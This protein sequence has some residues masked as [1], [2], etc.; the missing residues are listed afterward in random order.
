MQ[1]LE[2]WLRSLN[3]GEVIAALQRGEQLPETRVAVRGWAIVFVALPKGQPGLE[4]N[5]RLVGIGPV[6][7]G[8]TNDVSAA[9]QTIAGKASRYGE[10]NAPFVVA[11]LQSWPF[12]DRDAVEVLYG[13]EAVRVDPIDANSGQLVRLR[14]GTWAT[15]SRRV[16]A[17]L[18]GAGILPW[19][20]AGT[21]PRL[22]PN[23]AAAHPLDE[24]SLRVPI[25]HLQAAGGLSSSGP[26]D[27]PAALLGL[28][29]SW[30]GPEDPW[31][32]G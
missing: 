18:F 26:A 20:I 9:R 23:P 5:D 21:W 1:P 30:P 28:D 32:A 19:T 15:G 3:R 27:T 22:W 10:L 14:D 31:D 7:V 16:S 2:K 11:V 29:E 12:N 24:Q 6:S 25:V 17:V 4:P 8:Y 13:S